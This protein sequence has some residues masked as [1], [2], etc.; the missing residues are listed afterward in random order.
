MAVAG[1]VQA[2]GDLSGE[3][4]STLGARVPPT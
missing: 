1:R 3:G 2:V 4:V